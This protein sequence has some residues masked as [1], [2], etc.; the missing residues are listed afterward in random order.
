MVISNFAAKKLGGGGGGGEA[1]IFLTQIIEPNV[2]ME[3]KT[4]S[5]TFQAVSIKLPKRC[6]LVP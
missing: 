2:N 5:L 6:I 1:K 4:L 3:N